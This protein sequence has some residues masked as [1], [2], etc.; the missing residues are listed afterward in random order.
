MH[1]I[2]VIG[3][4]LPTHLRAMACATALR[5]SRGSGLTRLGAEFKTGMLS[6]HIPS[7]PFTLRG[8]VGT[9][10]RSWPRKPPILVCSSPR[11]L[12]EHPNVSTHCQMSPE[13][14]IVCSSESLTK[15]YS[16]HELLLYPS[17]LLKASF[18]SNLVFS[19]VKDDV[20]YKTCHLTLFTF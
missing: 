11:C 6:F 9:S 10:H 17:S 15:T 3:L 5:H 13:A 16:F 12:A 1:K 8:E 20:F 2:V 18:I 4:C 7:I 19:Y 14:Q